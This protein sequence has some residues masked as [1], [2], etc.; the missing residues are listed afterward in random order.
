MATGFSYWGSDQIQE[1]WAKDVIIEA[2]DIMVMDKFIGT[3]VDSII[4]KRTDLQKVKGDRINFDILVKM[5]GTP[6]TGNSELKGNEEKL[7]FYTDTATID[8]TRHAFLK[9]GR[10]EDIKSSKDMLSLGKDVLKTFFAEIMDEYCVRHLCGDTSITWPAAGIDSTATYRKFWAGDATADNNTSTNDWLNMYD[11]SRL[12][13]LARVAT[14]KFRGIKMQGKDHLVMIIHP[15]QTFQLKT[16]ATYM[17]AVRE[18]MPRSEQGNPLFNGLLTTVDGVALYEDENI[19]TPY[20]N[21]RRAVLC[22]SQ[23]AIMPFGGG[24]Y[25]DEDHDDYGERHGIGMD[26]VWGI[27]KTVFNSV[28]Y[29]VMTMGSYAPT[30]AGK[31]H[32]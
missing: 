2:M 21:V 22:G 19:I 15:Y 18:A 8:R 7:V 24:P 32:T 20:S 11:I 4:Q 9:R 5:S 12:R 3:S 1:A 10:L 6:T 23:A 28:D 16:D 30:P 29:S 27:K 13:A 14:P 25:A 31:S 17:Q 26:L